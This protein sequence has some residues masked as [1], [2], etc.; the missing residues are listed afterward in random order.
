MKVTSD[1]IAYIQWYDDKEEV[2]KEKAVKKNRKLRYAK[3]NQFSKYIE[4]SKN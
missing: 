3:V 4:K 2:E 1:T